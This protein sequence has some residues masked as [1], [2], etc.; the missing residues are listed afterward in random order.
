MREPIDTDNSLQRRD[1]ATPFP[2]EVDPSQEWDGNDGPWSTFAV[3]VGTPPQVV[4]VLPGT[5][6]N[7]QMVV[8]PEGCMASQDT[9]ACPNLR[10]LTFKA[11]ESTTWENNTLYSSTS[12]YSLGVEKRLGYQGNGLFGYDNLTLGWLGSDGPSSNNQSIA[13]IATKD[14]FLGVLGLNPR[15][16]NFSTFNNP[17]PSLLQN[18]RDT[19]KIASLS[20]SYTAGNQYRFNNVL[21]QLIL[22]GYDRSRFVSNQIYIPFDS[23]DVVDLSVNIESITSSDANGTQA[24]LPSKGIS[25]Y[26]DSSVSQIWLPLDACRRF[27]D[28]FGIIWNQDLE[29]YLVNNTQH[30]KLLSRNA[31]IIFKIGHFSTNQTVDITFPYAAFDLTLSYPFTTNPVR[32]FPLKRATNDTQYTLGRVFFQE[33]YV[34]ADYE[35]KNFSVSQCSWDASLE[36]DI[37]VIFPLQNGQIPHSDNPAARLHPGALAGIAIGVFSGF[38]I[39]AYFIFRYFVKPKMVQNG[40]SRS[41]PSTDSC[42]DDKRGEF[43]DIPPPTPYQAHLWASNEDAASDVS[44]ASIRSENMTIASSIV[45][46]HRTQQSQRGTSPTRDKS[47]P[48]V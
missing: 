37:Q 20:W 28:D 33:A 7:Q 44:G 41:G 26:L 9:S 48:L 19:Q 2:V 31:N 17:V 6:S 13:G 42:E 39:A 40:T 46:S 24:L 4:R 32:Y 15:P 21:G 34:I 16:T 43:D 18:L 45:P 47:N 12:I 14:F 10:G 38:I 23:Q 8:L 11:N 36:K 30:E 22:G 35:R 1:I 27:E 25:A 3:R 5:G 29:L